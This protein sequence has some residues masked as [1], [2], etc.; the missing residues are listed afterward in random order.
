L[1]PGAR[2]IE[3]ELAGRFGVSRGP[4]REAIRDLAR[5]GL[6]VTRPH[7]GVFVCTPS[8]TDLEEIFVFREALEIAAAKLALAKVLPVDID[9]LQG[10]LDAMDAARAK[11][12]SAAGT[13]L[14]L[15]FHREIFMIAGA[16]RLLR[17]QDDL[18]A[19]MLL[20]AKIN[21]T[22]NHD[23][24]PPPTLHR[25]IF[26]AMAD[27]AEEEVVA[28]IEEHYEWSGDRLL[29]GRNVGPEAAVRERN[30]RVVGSRAAAASAN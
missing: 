9:R 2:L 5:A 18:L 3:T 14:D 11:R 28:A 21:E 27:G 8:D 30:R 16:G 25:A 1:S 12:D 13:A 29:G 4:V 10:L 6:V 23:V 24:Y 7:Q 20:S 19:E 26:N 22:M 15:K 17:A